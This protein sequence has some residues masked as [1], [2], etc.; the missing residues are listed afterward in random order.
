V[1]V[2]ITGPAN[3]VCSGTTN[4]QYSIAAVPGATSYTWTAPSNASIV[5]GQ[6]TA[7][8]R[9]N[10][11]NGFSSGTLSVRAVNSCGT[12]A[13]RTLAITSVP[14]MPGAINGPATFCANSNIVYSISAVTG[15]TTYNW[16]VPTG[17]SITSGQGTTSITV[18][19]GTHSG[20]IKVRAGNACGYSAYQLLNVTKTCREAGDLVE[21]E[22]TFKIN[23]YPNPS[24]SQFSIAVTSSEETKYILVVRDITGR[25][26]MVRENIPSDQE[27][28]FGSELVTGI[29]FTEIILGNERK[30]LKVIKQ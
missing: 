11:G 5:N 14:P 9:L 4:V 28:T 27:I 3:S 13:A 16:V 8:V 21:A 29:Y 19:H 2:S 30:I 12:S 1:P 17:A 23:V 7:T 25:E 20:K 10:F 18:H 15:A 22:N 26:I 24:S 6:G